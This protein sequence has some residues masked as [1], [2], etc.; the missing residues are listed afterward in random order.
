M[1]GDQIGEET[2]KVTSFRVLDA[3]GPKVEVTFQ[4]QGK[5]LGKDYRGRASYWSE[6]QPGGFLYGEG[7]GMYMTAD[8]GMAV[9]KG[10]GIGKLTP[11]GGTSFRG[12]LYFV[13]ARG[14]LAELA[15]TTG[16]FEHE[17]D[18]DNNNASKLWAWK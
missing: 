5:I 15:G 4:S 1:L 11:K 6:M 8:G 7:Q 9:W 13:S 16:V 12:A 14:S 3:A 10:Q 18:G 17:N 2:G